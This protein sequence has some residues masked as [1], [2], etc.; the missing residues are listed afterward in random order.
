MK[1]LILILP[2]L[3]GTLLFGQSEDGVHQGMVRFQ[4]TVALGFDTNK[5][6]Y[7]KGE[8]RYYIYGEFEYLLND[9]IGLNGSI[10][11]NLGSSQRV[12]LVTETAPQEDGY[13]HS[14]FTGPV[15]HFLPNQAFDLFV[16]V[17]PGFSYLKVHHAEPY[18]LITSTQF[19][20][21]GSIFGGAAYYGSFFHLFAQ[22]RYVASPFMN[23]L[24]QRNFND[25]RLCIGLG[26]NFN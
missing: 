8:Q 24:A 13:V 6:V 12:S 14:V 20:P 5:Q 23:N 19:G 4:G 1:K 18:D 3:F 16:G 26:F 9:H 17:Q 2:L 11:A 25:L 22:A 7:A 10:F 15:Y 21:T